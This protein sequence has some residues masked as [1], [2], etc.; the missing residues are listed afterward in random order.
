M[1]SKAE[2]SNLIMSCFFWQNENRPGWSWLARRLI[3]QHFYCLR[4]VRQ[5]PEIQNNISATSLHLK[6]NWIH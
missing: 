6:D 5:G 4:T 1:S 3:L 2:V